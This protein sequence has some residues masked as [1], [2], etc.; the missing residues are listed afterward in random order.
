MYLE[1]LRIAIADNIFRNMSSDTVTGF[2]IETFDSVSALVKMEQKNNEVK[3][4]W[5]LE[6][7]NWRISEFS[8]ISTISDNAV[9]VQAE[10]DEKVQEIEN[11]TV[12]IKYLDKS[13]MVFLGTGFNQLSIDYSNV[14]SRYLGDFFRYV[15]AG[16]SLEGGKTKVRLIDQDKIERYKYYSFT[17]YISGNLPIHFKEKFVL[18]PFLRFGL[19]GMMFPDVETLSGMNVHWFYNMGVDALFKFRSCYLFAGVDGKQKFLLP[20]NVI[21]GI[22]IMNKFV[23]EIHVGIVF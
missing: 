5:I 13:T 7:G 22:E 4:A 20:S 14:V 23:P 18:S 1:G 12:Y 2:S 16:F 3:F 9:A 19:G 11:R 8:N 6:Y 21:N 17:P 10:K 15:Y